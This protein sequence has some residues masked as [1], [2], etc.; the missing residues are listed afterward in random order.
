MKSSYNLP[1]K[2][3]WQLLSLLPELAVIINFETVLKLIL[4]LLGDCLFHIPFP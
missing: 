3:Y 4:P 1:F 2:V